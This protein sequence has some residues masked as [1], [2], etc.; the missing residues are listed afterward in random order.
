VQDPRD[1]AR[2]DTETAL[3]VTTATPHSTTPSSIKP[4]TAIEHAA[5]AGYTLGRLRRLLSGY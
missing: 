4:A 1:P 3:N 2:R 5:V